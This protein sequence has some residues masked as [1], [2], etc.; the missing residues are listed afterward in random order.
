[1][2]DLPV[3]ECARPAARIIRTSPQSFGPVL[4]GRLLRPGGGRATSIL[5]FTG[6]A[7][8]CFVRTA[9]RV[10][11]AVRCAADAVCAG[12]F[13]APVFHSSSGCDPAQRLVKRDHIVVA[14]EM[15]HDQDLLG[16]IERPL[17]VEDGE[18]TVDSL[19]IARLGKTVSYG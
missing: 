8:E 10:L 17:R 13:S 19:C 1:M 11:N 16:A 5:L 15:Q 6:R 14:G 9:F 4:G 2:S 7:R 3:F 12:V 18:V